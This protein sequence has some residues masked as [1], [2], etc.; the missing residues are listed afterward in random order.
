MS[1]EFVE[2]S[3]ILDKFPEMGRIVPEIGDSKKVAA[4]G[5]SHIQV[6]AHKDTDIHGLWQR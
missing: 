1:Q 6:Q 4:I 2:K 3:E 5:N